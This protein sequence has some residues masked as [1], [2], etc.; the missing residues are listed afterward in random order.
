VQA[1][2]SVNNW[3]L[4]LTS[5]RLQAA[6]KAQYEQQQMARYN[7]GEEQVSWDPTTWHNVVGAR[8]V[9]MQGLSQASEPWNLDGAR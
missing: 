4:D 7:Q 6:E 1:L 5:P 8:K 9:R 3:N 2:H